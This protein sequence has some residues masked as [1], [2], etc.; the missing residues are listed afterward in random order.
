M[1][2]GQLETMYAAKKN[3]IN[4]ILIIVCAVPEVGGGQPA[5]A[6]VVLAVTERAAG[7]AVD[8]LRL[9]QRKVPAARSEPDVLG[10]RGRIGVG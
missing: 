7:R 8:G 6:R 9:F 3:I 10:G 4:N 5:P 2:N 1:T